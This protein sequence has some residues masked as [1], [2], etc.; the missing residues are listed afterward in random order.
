MYVCVEVKFDFIF[1]E[2]FLKFANGYKQRK[3]RRDKFLFRA[4]N[5]PTD[6]Y[7]LY[8]F[9]MYS[10]MDGGRGGRV[11]FSWG[12]AG[13][14]Q[15]IFAA[16]EAGKQFESCLYDMA[17]AHVPVYLESTRLFICIAAGPPSVSSS[18]SSSP[19]GSSEPISDW[20]YIGWSTERESYGPIWQISASAR[21]QFFLNGIE[22]EMMPRRLTYTHTHTLE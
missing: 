13:P 17:G 20:E 16:P 21:R 19:L 10:W 11:G 15:W 18:S 2:W 6:V 8:V 4:E 12:F 5:S 7:S 1:A 22:L 14:D 3:W 9:Y